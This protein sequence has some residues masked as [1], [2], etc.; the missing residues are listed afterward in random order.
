MSR[1]RDRRSGGF[2][3]SAV[4]DVVELTD[5]IATFNAYWHNA[6]EK[7]PHMIVAKWCKSMDP[8][9]NAIVKCLQIS[10]G[11]TLTVEF[12]SHSHDRSLIYSFIH[13]FIYSLVSIQKKDWYRM[14]QNSNASPGLKS[15]E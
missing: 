2:V 8:R 5:G 14:I 13:S 4:E 3:V 15:E 9:I 12:Y 10:R 11:V 7:N 1:I 6:S